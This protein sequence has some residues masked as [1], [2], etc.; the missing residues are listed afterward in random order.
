MSHN[1]YLDSKTNNNNNN[2][3]HNDNNGSNKR[4]ENSSIGKYNAQ[5]LALAWTVNNVTYKLHSNFF[6]YISH[7]I[8]NLI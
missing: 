6:T 2:H 5:L 1:Y 3:N 4:N 7:K 8:I